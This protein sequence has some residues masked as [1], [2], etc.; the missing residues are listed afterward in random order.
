MKLKKEGILLKKIYWDFSGGP[1]VMNM[2]SDAEGVVP[3]LMGELN[4]TCCRAAK[5]R[6]RS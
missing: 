6:D 2:P 5:Q 3:A 1:V 4:S